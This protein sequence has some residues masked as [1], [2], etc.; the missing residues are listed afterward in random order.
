[1]GNVPPEDSPGFPKYP[2]SIDKVTTVMELFL[3]PVARVV[4]ILGLPTSPSTV[5]VKSVD[6][7]KPA[8]CKARTLVFFS[9]VPKSSTDFDRTGD[10]H[11]QF[12]VG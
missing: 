4:E 8:E 6:K 9:Q 2:H 11:L 3:I 12:N 5:F 7:Y 10:V 1:M